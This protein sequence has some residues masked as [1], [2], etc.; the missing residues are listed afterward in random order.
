M[1]SLSNIFDNP[2]KG[3]PLVLHAICF[4]IAGFTPSFF[5]KI[6]LRER[7]VP[8]RARK[9]QAAMLFPGPI[10]IHRPTAMQNRRSHRKRLKKA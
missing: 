6:P 9:Q 2:T 8:S 4:I 3:N 10:F 1:L 7:P 5:N